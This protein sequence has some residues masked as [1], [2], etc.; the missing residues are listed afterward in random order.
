MDI[1]VITAVYAFMLFLILA[2]RDLVASFF[3]IRDRRRLREAARERR[4]AL[5][6]EALRDDRF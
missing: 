6:L 3:D 5:Q 1:F 2:I 4:R